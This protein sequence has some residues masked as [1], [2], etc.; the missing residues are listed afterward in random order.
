MEGAIA[1]QSTVDMDM[2]DVKSSELPEEV[3]QDEMTTPEKPKSA[4]KE[5]STPSRELSPAPAEINPTLEEP[6]PTPEKSSSAPEAKK[7]KPTLKVRENLMYWKCN[8]AL[9]D[10][11]ICG[12]YNEVNFR[13]CKDCKSRRGVG[14]DGTDAY[15]TKIAK[16]VLV[17]N[18]NGN[19]FWQYVTEE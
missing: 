8:Q 16:I 9:H 19:E 2:K 3:P 10:G 18:T 17:N 15:G 7:T 1:K 13:Q 11:G 5:P 14:D 12:S 4:P 6:S